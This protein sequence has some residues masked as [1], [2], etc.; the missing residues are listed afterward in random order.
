MKKVKSDELRSEYHRDS[1]G[2]GVRGKHF[3]A[4]QKGSNLVLLKPD[5]AAAFPSEKAVNQAL[6]SLL[7]IAHHSISP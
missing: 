1:L 4:Y 6:R 7:N 2:R 3:K 5:I